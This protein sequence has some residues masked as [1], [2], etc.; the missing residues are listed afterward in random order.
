[1]CEMLGFSV[2]AAR[3]PGVAA[4]ERQ[5]TK[6]VRPT[7]MPASG[8]DHGRCTEGRQRRQGLDGAF[9]ELRGRER[10]LQRTRGR[11]SEHAAWPPPY[12]RDS[13]LYLRFR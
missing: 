12:P 5:E 4:P 8:R 11:T 7:M 3:E 2:M 10:S 13:R 9:P 6:A 1:M